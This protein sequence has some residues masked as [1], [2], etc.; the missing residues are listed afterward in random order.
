MK[1]ISFLLL[2]VFGMTLIVGCKKIQIASQ[3]KPESLKVDGNDSDWEKIPLAMSDKINGVM[4][5]VND[6]ENQYIILKLSDKRLARRIRT[7]G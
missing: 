7:M 4:G 2:I 5:V 6:A 1:K 3:W